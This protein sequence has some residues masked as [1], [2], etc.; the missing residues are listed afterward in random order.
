MYTQIYVDSLLLNHY[1]ITFVLQTNFWD[2]H[3]LHYQSIESNVFVMMEP[4]D[5]T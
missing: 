4:C 2:F 3:S 1:M 5:L